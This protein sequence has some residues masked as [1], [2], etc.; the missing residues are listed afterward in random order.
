MALDE[1]LTARVRELIAPFADNVEEKKMFGGTCFMV[2]DKMCIGVKAEHIMVRLDPMQQEE[3]LG[4]EG[5]MPM[6]MKGKELKGYVFVDPETI[7]TKAKL[8]YWVSLAL[9]YNAIA[10]PSKKKKK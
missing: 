10:K 6:K 8:N 9:Q 5:C 1:K 3:V 4:K 2:N 7:T